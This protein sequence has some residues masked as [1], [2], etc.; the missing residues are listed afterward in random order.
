MRPGCRRGHRDRH[1]RDGRRNHHGHHRRHRDR[2]H[3]GDHGHR[4]GAHLDAGLR[5]GRA[6]CPGWDAPRRDGAR[7]D[8]GRERRDRQAASASPAAEQRG[9]CRDAADRQDDPD[10]CLGSTRTGCCRDA[11]RPDDRRGAA[12][13]VPRSAREHPGGPTRGPRVPQARAQPDAD[14]EQAPRLSGQQEWPPVQP[15]PGRQ[16][17]VLPAAR[18]ARP[19][20]APRGLAQRGSARPWPGRGSGWLQ[21]ERRGWQPSPGQRQLPLGAGTSPCSDAR[22]GLPLSSSRS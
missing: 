10:A 7:P 20:P 16:E 12:Q 14:R 11:V 6:S 18:L 15:V 1:H 17:P 9:C 2:H 3:R 13:R 5:H 21:P 19:E 22:Q 8:A 4:P